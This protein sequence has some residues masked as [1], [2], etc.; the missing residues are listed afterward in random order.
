MKI[1]ERTAGGFFIGIDGGGTRSRLVA[2]D[3]NMETVC[4]LQGGST[5]IA[6]ETYEGVYTNIKNLLNEFTTTIQAGLQDILSLCIG[7]AGASTGNNVQLLEKIFRDIGYMGKLTIMNDAELVLLAATKCEPG[8]IIISGTGSVG[9]AIDKEG[10]THR[11]GGWGHLIDD[12]G[13]GYRI[14]MD[15]IQAALM[16]YDGR[17]EKTVLTKMVTDFFDVKTPD[18]ILGYVYGSHFHKSKIAEIATLVK[19]AA[20]KNDP[21]AIKIQQQAASDLILLCHALI[22]KSGLHVHNI[23]LS[24][25]V[26][27]HN[28]AIRHAFEA[29]IY[30]KFP[31]VQIIPMSK[32][33]EIGAAQIALEAYA[34]NLS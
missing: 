15:A 18:K 19:D 33:A 7:S 31:N 1:D 20:T 9:Y 6:S 17:G 2:M 12:A 5:N 25:S 21:A 11:A 34:K 32:S 29:A 22:K 30:G 28:Q 4:H 16:D 26:I 23:V 27:L 8:I 10:A 24:G 3:E 14:G 13:S